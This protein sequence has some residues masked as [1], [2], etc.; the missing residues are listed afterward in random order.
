MFHHL[1]MTWHW[2]FRG[3]GSG[4]GSDELYPIPSQSCV[5][6][7]SCILGVVWYWRHFWWQCVPSSSDDDDIIW[8]WRWCWYEVY[9][10]SPYAR[11]HQMSGGGSPS[12]LVVMCLCVSNH[13]IIN[14]NNPTPTSDDREGCLYIGVERWAPTLLS[15]GGEAMWLSCLTE[16]FVCLIVWRRT[17][18]PGLCLM[19]LLQCVEV[20]STSNENLWNVC[21]LCDQAEGEK[22][23]E[24]IGCVCVFAWPPICAQ[25]LEWNLICADNIMKA[26]SALPISIYIIGVC[27][28]YINK[29]IIDSYYNKRKYGSKP[30]WR[31][32]KRH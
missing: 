31:R 17:G 11:K 32:K 24:T 7:T 3:L 20:E 28:T 16:L 14:P 30:Y 4:R 8:K 5:L 13:C 25:T 27:K 26:S 9:Y 22:T 6:M 18:K 2:A 15:G 29:Y 10:Y 19:S 21:V 12:V 23:G 1:H